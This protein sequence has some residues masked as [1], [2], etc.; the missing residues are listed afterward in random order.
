MNCP[1]QTSETILS[2]DRHITKRA[3]L[4]P[5]EEEKLSK[6]DEILD[7]HLEE[8]LADTEAILDECKEHKAQLEAARQFP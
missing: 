5:E 1:P 7:P 3:S 8:S 2:R 4:L 6:I